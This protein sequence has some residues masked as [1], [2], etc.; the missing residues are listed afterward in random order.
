MW[1]HWLTTG[2]RGSSADVAHRRSRARLRRRHAVARR[3]DP[4]GPQGRTTLYNDVLITGCSSTLQSFRCGLALADLVG[5]Q[6]PD[7]ELAA[8]AL[9]HALVAHPE[10]FTPKDRWSMD[11]TTRC[12]A[13][14]CAATGALSGSVTAGTRSSSR[15][16]ARCVSDQPWVTGAETCELAIALHTLGEDGRHAGWCA[17]CSTPVTTTAATGP[18]GSSPI[19]SCGR[20][21]V[22]L[23]CQRRCCSPSMRSRGRA[24]QRAFLRKRSPLGA[25]AECVCGAGSG[26]SLQSVR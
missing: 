21:S 5:E 16:G 14:R 20:A 22:P 4:L 8:G 23:D 7:W 13:V 3:G 26:G 19:R 1:H 11:W 6:Q 2:D 17:T 9:H 18:A 15:L 24:H 10:V 25:D 12:S